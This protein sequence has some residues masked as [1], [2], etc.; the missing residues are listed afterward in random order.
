VAPI[1]AA[2]VG[3]PVYTV[4]G[5]ALMGTFIAS[6]DGV[7]FYQYLF[8]VYANMTVAPDRLLGILFG[9]GGIFRDVS[10]GSN[11]EV[12]PC[13]AHQ[14]HP[15]RVRAVRGDSVHRWL[16]LIWLRRNCIRL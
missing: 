16:F 6:V 1:F 13:P 7:A 10:R 15:L 5:A 8:L 3:L 4:A 11:P 2:I 12:C 14:E 9:H